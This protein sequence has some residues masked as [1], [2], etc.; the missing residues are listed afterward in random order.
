M[1]IIQIKSN[2]IIKNYDG[3]DTVKITSDKNNI[4]F[5][6]VR[7][8]EIYVQ[9]DFNGN[10]YKS[11]KI[12]FYYQEKNMY[13]SNDDIIRICN[14]TNKWNGLP[15]TTKPYIQDD[16]NMEL[17]CDKCNLDHVFYNSIDP[18]CDYFIMLDKM[19]NNKI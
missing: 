8:Q 1:S 2:N 15:N 17:C 11:N 4:N 12:Y 6:N 13:V 16:V 18:G 7:E 5:I 3:F 10:L 9:I 14:T 19:A